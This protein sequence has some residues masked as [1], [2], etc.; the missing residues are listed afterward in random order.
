MSRTGVNGFLMEIFV[1]TKIFISHNFFFSSGHYLH[2][3]D[4]LLIKIYLVKGK[5]L[6]V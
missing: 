5:E 2:M 1:G 4:Y 3:F 6:Q